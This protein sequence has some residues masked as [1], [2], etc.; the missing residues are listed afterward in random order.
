MRVLSTGDQDRTGNAGSV[1]VSWRHYGIKGGAF[2]DFT[3]KDISVIRNCCHQS[4]CCYYPQ[5]T[6]KYSLEYVCVLNG[7][8]NQKENVPISS[9]VPLQKVRY[10]SIESISLWAQQFNNLWQ[11]YQLFKWS[12]GVA[13]IRWPDH[14]YQQMM[15]LVWHISYFCIVMSAK[16]L[17]LHLVG[18]N[19]DAQ[20]WNCRSR[21]YEAQIWSSLCLQM[22]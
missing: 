6:S 22:L 12:S 8:S 11:K 4:I 13:A 7:I 16:K 1:S 10:K 5:I 3:G 14:C 19:I 9:Y 18:Q 15:L 2:Y 20:Q 21:I 17:D